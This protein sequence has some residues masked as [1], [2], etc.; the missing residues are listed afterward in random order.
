MLRW[1]SVH[2]VCGVGVLQNI[3]HIL[4]FLH[5]SS[6]SHTVP[7]VKHVFFPPLP[8][9]SLSLYLNS[10]MHELR[11]LASFYIL[12]F[13]FG[14]PLRSKLDDILSQ[15]RWSSL[16]QSESIS[17]NTLQGEGVHQTLREGNNNNIELCVLTWILLTLK[18]VPFPLYNLNLLIV[19][20]I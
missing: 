15:P 1:E 11:F 9:P 10:N 14:D 18:Q 3:H 19:N 2:V 13:A 20:G 12:T 8:Q 17:R 4:R 16:Q 6:P 7:I 5:H